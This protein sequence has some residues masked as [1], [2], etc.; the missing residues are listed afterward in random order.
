MDQENLRNQYFETVSFWL[1]HLN[2][3]TLIV[4]A[5]KFNYKIENCINMS[6]HKH[7]FVNSHKLSNSQY[8]IIETNN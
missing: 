7:L 6:I 3:I 4:S 1:N 5:V 2:N 8:T